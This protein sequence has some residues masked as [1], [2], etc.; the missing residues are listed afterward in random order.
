M[1]EE[2]KRRR[3]GKKR[4]RKNVKKL[5]LEKIINR[6]RNRLIERKKYFL[7]GFKNY[8]SDLITIFF[9]VEK[10][11]FYFLFCSSFSLHFWLVRKS[12]EER[13]RKKSKRNWEKLKENMRKI[14]EKKR[15]KNEK[16]LIV[17]N[18]L[19][20]TVVKKHRLITFDI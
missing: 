1:K 18:G 11:T 12:L 17:I 8:W 9:V 16:I 2:R 7:I 10:N 3:K 13:E 5:R 6:T 4:R 20:Y 19:L 15:N 14:I